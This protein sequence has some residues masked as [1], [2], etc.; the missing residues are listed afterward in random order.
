MQQTVITEQDEKIM[1]WADSVDLLGPFANI[2][3]LRKKVS[4]A[5][6]GAL[7]TPRCNYIQ[8]VVIGRIVGETMKYS[9]STVDD[10][11]AAAENENNSMQL[12]LCDGLAV[13]YGWI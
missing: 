9:R 5:P 12:G 2:D 11:R 6:E 4:D 13:A 3:L 7:L 8:G 1:A 10:M